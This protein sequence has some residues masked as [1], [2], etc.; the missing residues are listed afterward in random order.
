[1][2]APVD[3]ARRR[4]ESDVQATRARLL[5][6]E[7]QKNDD[8]D[9]VLR[10]D[11]EQRRAD[12]RREKQRTMAVLAAIERDKAVKVASEE[13]ARRHDEESQRRRAEQEEERALLRL[14]AMDAQRKEQ[15][16]IE[17]TRRKAM[18]L[19]LQEREAAATELARWN[20][21]APALAR[22]EADH[23]EER[24]VAA[25]ERERM[26]NASR[27]LM[28]EV[29]SLRAEHA[30]QLLALG[31]QLAEK[32]A[33]HAQQLRVLGGQLAEKDASLA[34][35]NELADTHVRQ[36]EVLRVQLAGAESA[37]QELSAANRTRED[38]M[39]LEL[40]QARSIIGARDEALQQSNVREQQ[41]VQ[42]QAGMQAECQ[43][44]LQ[45][46]AAA[47]RELV[48]EL[49]GWRAAAEQAAARTS[50]IY[51]EMQR[52]VAVARLDGLREKG[53]AAEQQ[54]QAME[55]G[56][57]ADRIASGA[58]AYAAAQRHEAVV[59]A[60]VTAAALDAAHREIVEPLRRAHGLVVVAPSPGHEAG[61]GQMLLRGQQRNARQ[62]AADVLGEHMATLGQQLQAEM[63]HRTNQASVSVSAAAERADSLAKELAA[64]YEQLPAVRQSAAA[65]YNELLR[66]H[67]SLRRSQ[68]ELTNQLNEFEGDAAARHADLNKLETTVSS[69]SAQNQSLKIELEKAEQGA[70]TMAEDRMQ[71]KARLREL[72]AELDCWVRSGSGLE[73]LLSARE[74]ETEQQNEQVEHAM[75]QLQHQQ[76][77]TSSSRDEIAEVL[78]QAQ[79]SLLQRDGM[80]SELRS[81]LSRAEDVSARELA[82]YHSL[83]HTSKVI[84]A[85]AAAERELLEVE[86]RA[87]GADI[88]SW[89]ERVKI[90]ETELGGRS[91]DATRLSAE[92]EQLQRRLDETGA[93]QVAECDALREQLGAAMA[94]HSAECE[95][96]RQQLVETA[97]GSFV[98]L[99]SLRDDH[100]ASLV[101]QGDEHK[102]II[103]SIEDQH[104][105]IEDEHREKLASEEDRHRTAQLDGRGESQ[106]ACQDAAD[107]HRRAVFELT[108]K[109]REALL[110]TREELKSAVRERD[111]AREQLETT[112][113]EAGN[114][115][116]G[117]NFAAERTIAEVQAAAEKTM[118][119]VQA[120]MTEAQAAAEETVTEAQA[121]AEKKV[122]G[123]QAAAEKTMSEAQSAADRKVSEAR[124]A[125][126]K[127]V[128]EVQT[129]AEKAVTEAQA[130][131]EKAVQAAAKAAAAHLA[132]VEQESADRHDE[133]W[134]KAEAAA[135]KQLVCSQLQLQEAMDAISRLNMQSKRWS[136]DSAAAQVHVGELEEEQRT[137]R[138]HFVAVYGHCVSAGIWR[139]RI[140]RRTLQAWRRRVQVT[141]RVETAS[142]AAALANGRRCFSVWRDQMHAG[143]TQRARLRQ[144]LGRW[145]FT[146]KLGAWRRLCEHAELQ[147]RESTAQARREEREHQML[148]E[149]DGR[150]ADLQEMLE[151]ETAEKERLERKAEM[152]IKVAQVERTAR[153]R[154]EEDRA[155]SITRETA[156]C[157]AIEQRFARAHGQMEEELQTAREG[158]SSKVEQALEQQRRELEVSKRA[159]A[160]ADKRVAEAEAIATGARDELSMRGK[161]GDERLRKELQR[162]RNEV[163]RLKERTAEDEIA[164]RTLQDEKS[165]ALKRLERVWATQQSPRQRVGITASGDTSTART[166]AE[167]VRVPLARHAVDPQNA[168]DKPGMTPGAREKLQLQVAQHRAFAIAEKQARGNAEKARDEAVAIAAQATR[169]IEQMVNA[170]AAPAASPIQSP[171][172]GRPAHHLAPSRLAA[173]SPRAAGSG[174]WFLGDGRA[175]SA[176]DGET[177]KDS[178][179]SNLSDG[180]GSGLPPRASRRA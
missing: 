168:A 118:T 101:T 98:E 61:T 107:E 156:E 25:A 92:R 132:K 57:V 136:E 172:G 51:E 102:K 123:A 3:E 83:E 160:A 16:D 125:A 180:T 105:S 44:Q 46:A 119:E 134:R 48:A 104:R 142:R 63:A 174:E 114:E 145:Q 34:A 95:A 110:A 121:A 91:D 28:A 21:L 64:A 72:E 151:L 15:A 129:A 36:T 179:Q 10:R 141:S 43:L 153:E 115:I 175:L 77:M 97:A 161:G 87:A 116:A 54:A 120:A 177:D 14:E 73:T 8:A 84:E 71:T 93:I 155:A 6:M 166:M 9:A 32:G 100:R 167:S 56:T 69:L 139:P 85:K 127:L 165:A 140:Q 173:L 30:L 109:H 163:T 33:E 159:R 82:R 37:G 131:A 60:A 40:Q 27:H 66:V 147:R 47:Q 130:A 162:R 29:E 113:R 122:T 70:A 117:A 169:A 7:Q 76:M 49:T 59:A 39:R 22:A 178:N 67:E 52:R 24:V 11:L 86:L 103:A 146:Q 157:N 89:Q 2:E 112:S 170:A 13:R 1:M 133:N 94:S 99:A 137:Q 35:Y 171:D 152:S 148:S 4:R 111:Q 158:L 19:G 12:Q 26:E 62:L 78:A 81:Q 38:S 80:I 23:A 68:A 144:S 20:K 135:K 50:E 41:H 108:D 124:T 149:H 42:Q 74:Q 31:G 88:L 138:Q 176:A 17:A 45:E 75:Q 58:A 90:T 126:E 143:C 128:T 5:A 106:K 55:A 53:F 150:L 65:Q 164:I 18:E 79:G 154:A 96:F